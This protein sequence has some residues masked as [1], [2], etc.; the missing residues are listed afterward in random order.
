MGFTQEIVD[1][2]GLNDDDVKAR[3]YELNI[4]LT[5]EEAKKIQ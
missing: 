1:L 2:T 4:P 5:P 3:L